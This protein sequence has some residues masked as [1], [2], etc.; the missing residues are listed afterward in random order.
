M[1]ERSKGREAVSGSSLRGLVALMASKQA[2]VIG[3][4]GASVAPVTITSAL[5]SRIR[6]TA[7][8]TESRP[9]VQ[10]VDT[11]DTGPWAPTAPAT[12]AAME[13]GTK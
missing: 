1:R 5:P 4:I 12:S 2:T 10:P 7:C 6:S 9:E 8:P 3:E 11:S 13:L